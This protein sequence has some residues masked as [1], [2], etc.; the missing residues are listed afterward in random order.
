MA[1][2]RKPAFAKYLAGASVMAMGLGATS[3]MAQDDVPADETAQESTDDDDSVIVV[4]GIRGS[5]TT[6]RNLKRDADT[7]VDSITASDVATLPDLS[8]AEA[9]A[10]VPG[11]TVQQFDLSDPNSGDFPSPEGGNNLIRGLSFVRSEFNSREVF[12]ANQ[13]RALDFG[14]VPPELIGAVLVYKNSTADLIE[15]GIGGTID[16]RTIEPFDKKDSFLA[17]SAD[18]TYTTLREELSPDFTV[19]ASKRFNTGI[20]EFG[21]LA[22]FTHSELLS[23]IDNFQIGAILPED[24][25]V[26]PDGSEVVL[27]TPI[28]IP[29]GYQL[30]L[31]EIDRERQSY[32]VA[33]QWRNNTDTLKATFKYYRIDN[34]QERNEFTH[35][36]FADAERTIDGGN[37]IVGDFTTTPFQS[38]GL[39]VCGAGTAG[40]PNDSCVPTRAVNGLF[41]TGIISNQFRDWTGAQGAR[42]QNTAIDRNID[43]RTQD[44]SLNLDW[45]PT[46]Q[47]HVTLDAHKTKSRTDFSQVWGVNVFF[48]DYSLNIADIENP[49]ITLYPQAGNAPIRRF[50]GSEG[51]TVGSI[52]PGT[53]SSFFDNFGAPVS[54][55]LTDPGSNFFLAAADEFQVNDGDAWAIRGDVE[56]EFDNDGWFESV[57]FGGRYSEREQVNRTSGLNWGGISPPWNDQ[58]GLT[59]LPVSE[60]QVGYQSVDF[61][62]FFGGGLLNANSADTPTSFL[63]TPRALLNDY[64]AFLRAIF[65][66]PLIF[67]DGGELYFGG[68]G[69]AVNPV[70]GNTGTYSGAWNPLRAN[71]V[72]R[73]GALG[74]SEVTEEVMALYG[75]LNF[76]QYFDNGM[77]LSGNIGL[78]YT[79]AQITGTGGI[80]YINVEDPVAAG[81]N[82]ETTAFLAQADEGAITEEF[83]AQEHFLPSLNVKFGLNDQSLIRLAVSKNI[84][85]PRIDQLN[86]SRAIGASFAYDVDESVVP[87]VINDVEATQ[88]NQ[89]GGNPNL[90]PIESW[91][92]DLGFEHYYGAS[93]FISVTGFYKDITNNIITDTQAVDFVTLDGVEIPVLFTTDLN[94]DEASF[95]GVEFA[96]QHFFDSL[97]G[98]WGN[99][100]VQANYTYIE[101]DTNPPVPNIDTNGDGVPDASGPDGN[102]DGIPDDDLIAR[103]NLDNFLGTSKHNA[104][105]VGIYQDETFEFRLA[106]NYRSKFLISRADFVTGSPIF[107]DDGGQLDGSFKWNASENVQFRAQASNIL[108]TIQDQLQQV[109]L[110][111]QLLPRA[112]VKADSR[113]KVGVLIQ[114]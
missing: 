9:L 6:A 113:V 88:L 23:R 100:G 69:T 55:D 29:A 97:P 64:Q 25:V 40:F 60:A 101:A 107:V 87:P 68:D 70:T 72:F 38:D 41:E 22:A 37:R 74:V 26:Q 3:A 99:F 112:R 114:F 54:T 18:G 36:N 45:T 84:T 106:Y 76:G 32:Y 108:G 81:F 109:D 89:Y 67:E 39:A 48:A 5:L 30:R 56:Y 1:F 105:L 57:Q 78:R 93:N 63:F 77:S 92:Y 71:G 35:E 91:N 14:T 46:D 50:R 13:G 24:R 102:G 49:N 86:S 94:E 62:D 27:D 95:L 15:G 61:S 17:I 33:G 110:T 44:I 83:E 82:P 53:E 59:H 104:N 7:T 20:G 19:T 65:T 16:L 21:L 28:A 12:S 80:T 4:T 11:V 51:N 90:Q 43:T 79:R 31:D 103:Y 10:R 8:V 75:R 2:G 73:E 111:G 52:V 96:V 66:D 58:Y 42:A 85:R 47:W 98:I 34:L